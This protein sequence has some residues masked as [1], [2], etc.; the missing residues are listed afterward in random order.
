M[1]IELRVTTSIRSAAILVVGVALAAGLILPLAPTRAP[2]QTAVDPSVPT[3]S[4]PA[5]NPH[6]KIHHAGPR[7]QRAVG[8]VIQGADTA[9]LIATL[10][11]WQIDGPFAPSPD[12]GRDESP[13]LTAC[14][15]WLGFPYARTD[16]ESLTVRLASAQRASEL[17]SVVDRIQVADPDELNEIDRTAP[18]AP[19]PAG[20]GWLEGLLA[21]LGGAVAVGAGA[22]YLMV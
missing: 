8:T 3:A 19:R 22:R 9:S 20:W 16:S 13:V 5:A 2:A 11:W 12:P 17:D 7:A 18:P 1:S 10:P 14:D 21:M 6:R 15:L 4:E